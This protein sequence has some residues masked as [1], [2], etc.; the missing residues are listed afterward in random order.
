MI[1]EIAV[2]IEGLVPLCVHNI[3]LADPRNEWTKRIKEISSKRKKVDA[4]LDAIAK[5]EWFGSLYR[6]E[7]GDLI[8]PAEC[9][10]ATI[11]AAAKR[12]KEGPKAKLSVRCSDFVIEHDGGKDLEVMYDN[13]DFRYYKAVSVGQAT[14]MRMRPIFK[15]WSGTIRVEFDSDEV[16]ESTVRGWV[17]TAGIKV[18]FCERRPMFGR[19]KVVG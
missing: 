5:N 12:T 14:V 1:K 9:V 3:Q 16:N 7:T 2:K 4:D 18:G 13:A 11:L 10:D 19:F 17:E 15:K 6:N 8:I